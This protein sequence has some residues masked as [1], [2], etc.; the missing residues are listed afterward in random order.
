M[1]DETTNMKHVQVEEVDGGRMF[2]E[3]RRSNNNSFSFL[4]LE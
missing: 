4:T 3:G 2:V 1:N